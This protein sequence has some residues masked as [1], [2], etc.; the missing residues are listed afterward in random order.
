M[1]SLTIRRMRYGLTK[2]NVIILEMADLQMSDIFIVP[3]KYYLQDIKE[4]GKI[5]VKCGEIVL[6]IHTDKEKHNNE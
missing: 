1:I 2:V 4:N 3:F 5:H 6:S